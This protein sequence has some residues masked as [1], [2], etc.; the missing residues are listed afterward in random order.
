MFPEKIRKIFFRLIN[1]IFNLKLLLILTFLTI[2]ADYFSKSGPEFINKKIVDYTYDILGF[3][4]SF[5]FS[6]TLFRRLK[7]VKKFLFLCI[8]IFI[9]LAIFGLAFKQ[10]KIFD[11]LILDNLLGIIFIT[12]SFLGLYFL[13]SLTIKPFLW[14]KNKF[15]LL[16]KSALCKKVIKLLTKLLLTFIVIFLI[17]IIIFNQNISA[18]IY[19]EWE[20]QAKV[21]YYFAEQAKEDINIMIAL[22]KKQSDFLVTDRQLFKLPENLKT[23]KEDRRFFI[24]DYDRINNKQAK[25][26]FLPKK[27]KEYQKLKTEGFN[28]Y[29]KGFEN[30]MKATEHINKV[31]SLTNKLDSLDNM[32]FNY[33]TKNQEWDP[34]LVLAR[35][36]AAETQNMFDDKIINQNLK[37]YLDFRTQR[38]IDAYEFLTDPENKE[39]TKEKMDKF[40]SIILRE[41]NLPDLTI[42]ILNWSKQILESIQ[43]DMEKYHQLAFEQFTQADQYYKDNDL[44]NDLISKI[45]SKFSSKYPKII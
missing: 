25:I 43:T 31:F 34:N 44:K 23:A 7:N 13:I 37:D 41:P 36:L 35:N 3:Y 5:G 32:L 15:L 8:F 6:V 2:I 27:Y 11:N 42:I 40:T 28:N 21:D 26:P 12:S 4:T 24:N 29:K 30:F 38:L 19:N 9:D 17:F 18:F 1:F 14:L 45:L 33:L 39:F 10:P 22:Q 16:I 20:W